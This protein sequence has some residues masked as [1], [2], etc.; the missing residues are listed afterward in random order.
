[1]QR[2]VVAVLVFCGACRFTVEGL[3]NDSGSA[4]LAQGGG[5]DLA[6]PPGSDLA[7]LDLLPA[8]PCGNPP[9]LGSG[10]VAAQCVI[11]NPPHLDGD[12]ADW[13]ANLFTSM[14]KSTVVATGTWSNDPGVDDADLS[15]RWAVRWDLNFVYVAV[16][17]TDDIRKTPN[18]TALTDNDAA[19]LFFDGNHDRTATYG[20]DDAQLVFSADT[21]KAAYRNAMGVTWPAGAQQHFRND[22]ASW[23][24]EVAIPWTALFTT[25]SMGKLIGFDV[26]LDDNDTDSSDRQR[27]LVMWE[28]GDPRASCNNVPYCGTDVFG[29]VQLHGR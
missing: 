20:T 18:S 8:D 22:G 10:N 29:T 9:A 16:A 14:T 28:N 7:G 13:P 6:V 4:D 3:N 24:L 27:D 1:V 11:G 19:E 15:G 5:D 23:S 25:A 26:K 12:L 2:C 17:V 21:K